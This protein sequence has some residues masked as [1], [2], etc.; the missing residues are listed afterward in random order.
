MV[1]YILR[2]TTGMIT[3]AY[4]SFNQTMTVNRYKADT[5]PD[6]KIH[7]A[8]MSAPDGPHVGP[9]NLAIREAF[10]MQRLVAL[11]S[12]AF[13][14]AARKKKNTKNLMFLDLYE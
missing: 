1:N 13:F 9:M 8:N 11:I 10:H 3:Y 5:N 14:V 6:S 12:G 7:G 2:K 4:H